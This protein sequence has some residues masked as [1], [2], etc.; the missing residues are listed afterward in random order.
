MTGLPPGL[1]CNPLTGIISGR[2]IA[3]AGYSLTIKATNPRG[4]VSETT[5]IF[6][7]GMPDAGLGTFT[8]VGERHLLNNNLGARF[9]LTTSI[10]GTCSG[11]VT[12]GGRAKLPFV[13]V[14]LKSFGTSDFVL[15]AQITGLKMADTTPLSAQVD[16]NLT[17]AQAQLT[18]THPDGT[19]F[20]IPAWLHVTNAVLYATKY[21]LALDGAGFSNP[22]QDNTRPQ[23]YGLNTFTVNK[24]GGKLTH[25]GKLPDGTAL[26]GSTF[27]GLQGQVLVFQMLY[28]NKGS[29]VGSYTIAPNSLITLNTITGSLSWMK[30]AQLATSTDTVYKAGFGP[31]TLTA[32]G[33]AYEA[34]LAGQRVLGATSVAAP[35]TNSR[36]IFSLG[37]L[38][39]PFT[40]PV[41]ITNPS[42]TSLTN[43]AAINAPALNGTTMTV[44]TASTGAIRGS[45]TLGGPTTA[46]WFGQIVTVGAPPRGYGYF[47]LPTGVP[48]VTTSPKLSGRVV[49]AVP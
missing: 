21:A 1:R 18:L 43:T 15:S 32:L 33:G 22:A 28:G 42:A 30:P 31:L 2:P 19:Q 29:V 44:L 34:P 37:G 39:D 4:S 49:L 23:G 27:V 36:L 24:V 13:N 45:F 40:Q 3:S 46:P 8:G 47:L 6:V 11:S 17:N 10:A 12:L 25:A 38:T 7:F 20:V 16:I 41:R 9:D 14:L 48:T 5:G 26:S 35:A